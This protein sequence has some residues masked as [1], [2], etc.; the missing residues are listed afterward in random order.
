MDGRIQ[1]T[2]VVFDHL[3]S[4]FGVGN[5]SLIVESTTM[6]DSDTTEPKNKNGYWQRIRR[7][8]RKKVV[9]RKHLS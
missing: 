8:R 7:T 6:P 3:V 1:S 5:F 4:T 2:P 9:E